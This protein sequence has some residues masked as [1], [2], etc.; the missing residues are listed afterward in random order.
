MG[1]KLLLLLVKLIILIFHLGVV[2]AETKFNITS[3]QMDTCRHYVIPRN[4]GYKYV[5]FFH[6]SAFKYTK[7]SEN[8]IFHLKF[9]V[10]AARDAHILLTEIPNPSLSDNVYEIVIGAGYNN[11][12]T[13]RNK[14]GR[15]S[16]TTNKHP[17]ILSASQYTPIEIIQLKNSTLMVSIPGYKEQPLMTFDDPHMLYPGYLSFASYGSIPATWF[18][19]CQFDGFEDE[20]EEEVHPMTPIELLVKNLN[21]KAENGSFPAD[22]KEVHLLL[23]TTFLTY[24]Q[25]HSM[26]HTRMNVKMTWYDPR[27]IWDPTDHYDIGFL[28]YHDNVIWQPTLLKINSIEHADEYY[29]IEHRIKIDYNGTVTSI[30]EN[31]V[32]SSWCPNAMKNWPNE[33]LL[34]DVIFGLD[35][36]PLGTLDLIYDGHWAHP[37]IETLSEWTLK[38][39][40]VSTVDN[41]NNMRYTDKKV[42]QSMVGDI[43]IEFEIARNSRFYKNVFSMPILTCQVLIILSFLLRGYRRGALLLVVVMVLLLGLMF[44]TKHAPKPYVPPIMMAYQHILR[45]ATFCYILHICLMWLELY[46]PRSKPYNW[47][48]SIVHFSPLRIALCM[49]LSDNDVFI[50]SDQQPWREVAKILNALCFVVINIIFIVVVVL[51][52]PHV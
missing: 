35:P 45:V 17:K 46:P 36:G 14:M 3:A 21:E 37:K 33:H 50:G 8:E 43:A 44:L 47:L 15:F 19:D 18:Y 11:Y 32:F 31:V 22:L 10:N 41:A 12:S 25:D 40:T 1:T 26:L 6:L 4:Q 52:L 39:I 2:K 28:H 20:L 23:D 51:L 34:C 38:A 24:Q 7:L 42:L 48:S 29:N 9:Y 30:F 27:V 5:D 13:I 16:V 49:R